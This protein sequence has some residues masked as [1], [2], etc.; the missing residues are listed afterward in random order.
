M[1]VWVM[2]W[3]IIRALHS[4]I[5]LIISGGLETYSSQLD[6][7]ALELAL[8]VVSGACWSGVLYGFIRT[9]ADPGPWNWSQTQTQQPQ[10]ALSQQS[11]YAP[12]VG[13]PPQVQQGRWGQEYPSQRPIYQPDTTHPPTSSRVAP[14]EV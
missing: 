10:M 11:N 4:L 9:A 5:Y 12:P 6:P 3:I 7:L 2:P 8:V 1:L 14:I 13:I